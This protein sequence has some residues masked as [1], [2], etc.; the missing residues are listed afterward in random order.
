MVHIPN[1]LTWVISTQP[2]KFQPVQQNLSRQPRIWCIP[3]T[4]GPYR[5][6]EGADIVQSLKCD[7]INSANKNYANPPEPP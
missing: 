4:R 3:P 1:P 6:R 7:N 5:N 2:T